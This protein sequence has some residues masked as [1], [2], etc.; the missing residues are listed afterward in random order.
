MV[1]NQTQYAER[2]KT[3]NKKW[4]ERQKKKNL[5]KHTRKIGNRLKER[6]K[7]L[8]IKTR[9]IQRKHESLL[10]ISNINNNNK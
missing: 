5:T 2:P 1:T 7:K 9:K 4:L 8:E 10:N 3:G 6:T